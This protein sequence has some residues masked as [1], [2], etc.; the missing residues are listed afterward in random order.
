MKNNHQQQIF[1]ALRKPVEKI[2]IDVD[3][4][5]TEKIVR[6]FLSVKHHFP[7]SQIE[8]EKSKKGVHFYVYPD[9][10]VSLLE[11][12]IIRSFCGDDM[13]RIKLS[14]QRLWLSEGDDIID[15]IFTQKN[16]F[17][18]VPFDMGAH[19]DPFNKEVKEILKYYGETNTHEKIKKLCEKMDFGFPNK[20]VACFQFSGEKKRHK[21]R[22]YAMEIYQ[23][24]ND[25]KFRIFQNY[26]PDSD[27]ILVIYGEENIKEYVEKFNSKFMLWHWEK[28]LKQ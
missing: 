10:P 8:A 2:G 27:Y 21:I 14:L 17:K 22:D 19:L 26:S 13:I 6:T 20:K 23:K 16:G 12:F 25:F 5:S 18:C 24:D 7:T 11:S 3:T 1:K 4:Q 9:R 28:I 15:L